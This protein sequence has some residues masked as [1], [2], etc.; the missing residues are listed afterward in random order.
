MLALG[1]SSIPDAY[2]TLVTGCFTPWSPLAEPDM[3]LQDYGL[4]AKSRHSRHEY[5]RLLSSPLSVGSCRTFGTIDYYTIH[6]DVACQAKRDGA[7][8]ERLLIHNTVIQ[9]S[10]MECFNYSLVM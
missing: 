8:P 1:F 9:N 7:N 3:M 5:T 4:S 10:N 2:E 6:D